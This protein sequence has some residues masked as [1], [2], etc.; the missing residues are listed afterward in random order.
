MWEAQ[1]ELSISLESSAEDVA[2]IRAWLAAVVS[3]GIRN[4]T[5]VR[6]YADF[7]LHISNADLDSRSAVIAKHVGG[8]P[9]RQFSTHRRW[10]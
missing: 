4:G 3:D 8:T 2:E 7:S 1:T 10:V 6:P 5:R 9:Q